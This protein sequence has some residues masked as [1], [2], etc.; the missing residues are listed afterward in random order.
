MKNRA[1][2][3]IW[4][5]TVTSLRSH[6]GRVAPANGATSWTC[7]NRLRKSGTTRISPTHGHKGSW[8]PGNP[9]TP[10]RVFPC[11]DRFEVW[12][13]KLLGLKP[14]A[15]GSYMEATEAWSGM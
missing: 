9:G 13:W 14:L 1:L 5:N 7:G 6:R 4:L 3:D 15:F 12:S 8:K 10:E 11:R 2:A